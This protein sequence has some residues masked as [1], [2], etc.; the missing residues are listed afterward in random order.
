[1]AKERGAET[2][3]REDLGVPAGR[4]AAAAAAAAGGRQCPF[5]NSAPPPLIRAGSLLQHLVAHLKFSVM[6]Y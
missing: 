1:M 2:N 3:P 4:Q 6:A 5:T